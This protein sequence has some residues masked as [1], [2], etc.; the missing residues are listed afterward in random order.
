M[1]LGVFLLVVLARSSVIQS[2]GV[3]E[4]PPWGEAQQ[5]GNY[6]QTRQQSTVQNEHLF[7][8][9]LDSWTHH[10]VR[11]ICGSENTLTHLTSTLDVPSLGLL[12]GWSF[13]ITVTYSNNSIHSYIYIYIS[14]SISC[15]YSIPFSS[16]FCSAFLLS[17]DRFEPL[18]E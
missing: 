1:E 13:A 12:G 10:D 11:R 15:V 18:D 3:S 7:R 17:G 9:L 16:G 6:W 14:I 8:D 2:D 5:T 4:S